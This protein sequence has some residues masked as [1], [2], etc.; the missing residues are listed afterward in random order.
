MKMEL[1]E[2]FDAKWGRRRLKTVAFFKKLYD[3]QLSIFGTSCPI[4]QN[5]DE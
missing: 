5:R 1:H 4:S 3:F 2:G